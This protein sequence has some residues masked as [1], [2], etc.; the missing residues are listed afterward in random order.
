[1]FFFTCSWLCFLPDTLWTLDIDKRICNNGHEKYLGFSLEKHWRPYF[2]EVP[3]ERIL[4]EK[5]K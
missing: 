3:V 2:V 5:E 4:R 1:M